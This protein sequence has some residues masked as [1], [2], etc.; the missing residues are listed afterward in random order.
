[1]S[2]QPNKDTI[3]IDVDD[4]ITAIIDKVRSSHGRIVALVL[5]KRATVFQSVVNM[6]LLKRTADSA[7][8]HLVLITNEAGLLPLAGS[9]GLYVA[10]TLQS[11]PEIPLAPQ[12]HDHANEDGE[13]AVD[14]SSDDERLDPTRAVGSF[15]ASSMA[16]SGAAADLDEDKPIELDNAAPMSPAAA[17]AT[18]LPKKGKGKFS[19]PDFNKFRTWIIIGGAALVV[20]IFMWYM[21][22]VVMP[23]AT[24]TIKTDSMA[25]P[26]D[27]DVTLDTEAEN[28]DVEEGTIPATMQQTQKTMT[29][30]VEATGQK[31]NGTQASGTVKMTARACGSVAPARDVPAGTGLTANG[32]TFIT[33]KA[34]SFKVDDV[35]DN[36]LA[37]VATSSTPV[38]A[39]SKGANGNIAPSEFKVVGRP[40]VTAVSSSPMTGGTSVIV[41]IVSQTDIDNASQ[42]ISAQDTAPIKA[43]LQKALESQG[44]LVIGETFTTGKPEITASAKVGDEAPTVTITQKTTYTLVGTRQADLKKLIDNAVSEE[45]D[46]TKQSILDYGIEDAVFKMQSQQNTKTLILFEGNVVAGSDLNTNEIKSQVAGKK[47]NTAKEVIGKY[48]GVTEVKVD[49]SPFWVKSIPKNQGKITVT[50]EQPV[51]SKDVKRQ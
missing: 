10:K 25:V 38:I 2:S 7:K 40:D 46:L 36:C 39:Q 23:R 22:F 44:L 31:D 49:Y 28:I 43:E 26:A 21:G 8:K 42:K 6:K 32:Q 9:V 16:S 1:M 20:L 51:I 19:I 47:A 41:K 18:K 13:E 3:Y 4:E 30:Q 11:K 24:I 48:P 5:P 33:Q 35:Q 17:K 50:V 45:I 34:T 14:M 29:Q 27:L 37:F 12:L 15:G